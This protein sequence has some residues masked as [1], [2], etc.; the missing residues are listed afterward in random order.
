MVDK[1]A[2][3]QA[4]LRVLWFCP[5]SIIPHI[6][7]TYFQLNVALISHKKK[8]CFLGNRGALDRKV[9]D[10]LGSKKKMENF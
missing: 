5:V 2:L 9:L 1:V 10:S 7:R 3:G 6:F 8:E 4:S